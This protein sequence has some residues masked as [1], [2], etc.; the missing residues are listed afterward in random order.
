[1]AA[2]LATALPLVPRIGVLSD[3]CIAA[4]LRGIVCRWVVD[5]VTVRPVARWEPDGEDRKPILHLRLVRACA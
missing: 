5:P 4:R 2:V 1:M 3:T